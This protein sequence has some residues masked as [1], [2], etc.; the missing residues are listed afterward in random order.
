MIKSFFKNK[1]VDEELKIPKHIA[2][3]MDGNGRWAKKR[4][5]PR[6]M[7]HKAGGENVKTITKA[8]SNFGV[9]YLTLYAFSTENWKRPETEV[10][11]LMDL[12]VFFLKNE[13]NELHENNVRIRTIGDISKLPDKTRQVLINSMEKTKDN[14]GLHLILALNYGSRNEIKLAVKHIAED[15]KQNKV[16]LENID[17]EL[18]ASYL[19]TA[20][21]PDPDLMVR[22]SGEVRLSNY[23]LW[24]MAYTEFHFVDTY[25]PDFGEAELLEAIEVYSNRQR[26]FGSV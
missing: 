6:N 22:T 23:L 21:T 9:K 13:L 3:I 19:D 18:I 17:E 2:I 24:Q 16:E 1:K 5:L 8:C 20:G 4:G 25:W 26:R 10:S 14:D 7:G 11:G 15:V 12:L